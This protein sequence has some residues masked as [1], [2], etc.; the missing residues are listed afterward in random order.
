MKYFAR[1]L[2]FAA[3]FFATVILDKLGWFG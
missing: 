3:G 2:A 1:I